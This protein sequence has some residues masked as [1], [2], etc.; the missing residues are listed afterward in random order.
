M[1]PT[2]YTQ[3]GDKI[4][5]HYT[6]KQLREFLTHGFREGNNG[7]ILIGEDG[8]FYKYKGFGTIENPWKYVLNLSMEHD[9]LYDGKSLSPEEYIK[10]F[11][12]VEEYTTTSHSMVIWDTKNDK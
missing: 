2:K 12:E 10:S 3:K 1:K 11:D 7:M 5:Y 9:P 6:F 4:T 8:E